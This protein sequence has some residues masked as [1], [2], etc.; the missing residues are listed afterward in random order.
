ML[1]GIFRLK[2]LG[3]KCERSRKIRTILNCFQ[4]GRRKIVSSLCSKTDSLCYG[5]TQ[6]ARKLGKAG[7]FE[8]NVVG[9]VWLRWKPTSIARLK[10]FNREAVERFYT[11]LQEVIEKTSE[12]RI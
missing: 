1:Y 4:C 7:T 11:L 5:L 8:D 2:S 3:L 9:K 10:G 6:V 12:G